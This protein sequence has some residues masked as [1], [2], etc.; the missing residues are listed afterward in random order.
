MKTLLLLR[1]AKSSWDNPG[2]RD[3]DRP[4]AP[5]GRRTAPLIGGYLRDRQLL[6]D[7][8][9][10]STARRARETY[11]LV[12]PAVGG[13]AIQF[14]QGLYLAPPAA[15]LRLVQATPAAVER[16]LVVGHN[17]G[18]QQFAVQLAGAGDEAARERLHAKFP[19]AGLAILTFAVARWKEVAPGAGRLESFVV[20]RDVA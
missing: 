12:V 8:V 17:P 4:L 5:R 18:L 16:L 15:L 11:D 14:E 7:L 6:P 9:L 1:H 2:G 10:C 13:A 19:T 3:I 20:P